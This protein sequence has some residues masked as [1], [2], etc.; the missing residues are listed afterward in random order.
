M[1]RPPS[2]PTVLL[3]EDHVAVRTLQRFL[4]Q[5]AGMTVVECDDLA[6]GERLLREFTPD[7]VVLDVNLPGGHGLSLLPLIDRA[8]TRVLVM[9]GMNQEHLAR[10]SL[11]DADAFMPKPF[12]PSAFLSQIQGLLPWPAA[13]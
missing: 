3:I 2:P 8:S 5:R 1:K 6:D 10:L 9:S 7:M 4:L 11:R 13:Q 12:E